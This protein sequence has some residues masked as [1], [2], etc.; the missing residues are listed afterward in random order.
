MLSRTNTL[1]KLD[2]LTPAA[3]T[4]AE[5]IDDLRAMWIDGTPTEEIAVRLGRSVSSVLTQV[6]R[7]GLPRRA[8][9]GR[10]PRNPEAAAVKKAPVRMNVIAFPV[11]TAGDAAAHNTA[12]AV[13]KARTCLM[14][15]SSFQSYGSHNRICNRC[16]D[17]NSYQA[18]DA[19][20]YCIKIA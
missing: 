5:Q 3:V 13:H 15:S 1:R 20:E 17:T 16:K 8:S 9:S 4:W 19:H 2:N 18:G 11:R 14:C 7:I 6:V 10:K 12:T